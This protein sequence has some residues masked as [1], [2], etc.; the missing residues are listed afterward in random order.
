[1][2][3]ISL[4]MVAVLAL[5]ALTVQSASKPTGNI[6][7][8]ANLL[9]E[10]KVDNKPVAIPS[11]KELPFPVG[12]YALASITAQAAGEEVNGKREIWSITSTGPFGK[13][14]QIEI[15][16]GETT[17]IDAG[18][19]LTL[20]AT[21]S[22]AQNTPQGKV[23]GINLQVLGKMGEQ[24]APNTLRKG[25]TVA[26]APQFEI[27]DEKGTSLAKGNFEYG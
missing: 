13:L 8:P 19:P 7:V 18:P 26:T 6:K 1:M 25:L 17:A 15:K 27:L 12:T 16:E 2:K 9:F 24:Y 3:R 4:V 20:K 11:G 22:K 10:L 21:V 5:F 14:A 23:V